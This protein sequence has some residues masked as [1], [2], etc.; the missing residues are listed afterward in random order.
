MGTAARKKAESCP[1]ACR[2]MCC[3]YVTTKID[4][5]RTKIDWDEI[6]WFLCHENVEVFIES[7]KWYVLFDTPCK[8]L[9]AK[10]RCVVYPRRPY[11][12]REHE[13]E[14]C[15]YWGEGEGKVTLRTPEDLKRFMKR[16]KLRL[17][18]A[19]DEP[20][21]AAGEAASPGIGPQRKRTRKTKQ[22]KG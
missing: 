13:V 18:M 16:R 9:D 12:C 4:A 17:R 21:E 14:N 2:G 8:N 1:E 22:A 10:S 11:V 19:W 20:D 6:Y 5:P 7:R 3:R 15:E